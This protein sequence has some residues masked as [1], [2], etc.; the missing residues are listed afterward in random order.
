MVHHPMLLE[1]LPMKME[2]LMWI[3][4]LLLGLL[5]CGFAEQYLGYLWILPGAMIATFCLGKIG[6]L[7]GQKKSDDDKPPK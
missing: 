2:K 7:P 3:L 4:I 6:W 1:S 5:A